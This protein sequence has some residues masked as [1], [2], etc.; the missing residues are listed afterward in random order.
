MR[1][2][3]EMKHFFILGF[4]I[5]A[6]G[7]V[8]ASPVFALTVAPV[9][10]EITGDPGT[11]VTGEMQLFNEQSD[12]KTYYSSFA[13]F[14]ASGETGAP[15]FVD[16]K[17]GLAT[18]MH[19]EAQVTLE[20]NEFKKIPFSITIPKDAE[21]G[22]HFAAIFWGSEPPNAEGGQVA[23][24]GKVGI[25]VLLKVSGYVKEGGGLLSFTIQDNQKFFTTLP[26]QFSYRV[27][28]TGGDRIVPSG[29][30]DIKNLLVIPSA[31]LNANKKDS[32]VLPNSIRKIETVW[33]SEPQKQDEQNKPGFFAMALAELKDFHVGWYSAQLH[34]TLAK[35]TNVVSSRV[36]FFVLPWQLLIIA[37]IVLLIIL[38]IGYFGI[39]RYNKMIIAKAIALH[40][41]MPNE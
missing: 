34:I 13:N 19:T 3:N 20:K 38:L 39:G 27:S 18:W 14:E 31:K 17:E 11:T 35:D 7:L 25:L 26:V 37:G 10:L 1:E 4:L 36:W 15:H 32:S 33:G 29:S 41:T 23:V 16:A 5:M 28:N 24:G 6:A 22:G 30:L 9:K 12:A 8:S 2:S 40:K 21:P